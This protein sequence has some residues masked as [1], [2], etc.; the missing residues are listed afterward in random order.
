MSIKYNKEN[1]LFKNFFITMGK[2]TLPASVHF[3][4]FQCLSFSVTGFVSRSCVCA[5]LGSQPLL[6]PSF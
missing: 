1:D 5:V 4:E 2:L 3:D 6:S